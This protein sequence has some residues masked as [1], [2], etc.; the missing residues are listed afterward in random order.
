LNA[1]A[2]YEAGGSDNFDN[3]RWN[4]ALPIIRLGDMTSHGGRVITAS[5]THTVAG[6]GIARVGDKIFC[7]MPG[8][9]VNVIVNGALTF[10]IGGRMVALQGHYGACGCM[11]ISSLVSATHG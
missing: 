2:E 4:M 6:I 5:V 1:A 11:L 3:E 7:P 9:G 10:L 8:H